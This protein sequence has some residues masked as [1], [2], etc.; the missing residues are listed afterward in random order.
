MNKIKLRTLSVKSFV[1][2]LDKENSFTVKGGSIQTC[3]PQADSLCA[4][5]TECCP[6]GVH[7]CPPVEFTQHGCPSGGNNGPVASV[8]LCGTI[9]DPN[10]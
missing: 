9:V 2:R 3:V 1:T 7:P 10:Q 6:V 5:E 8:D 4:A